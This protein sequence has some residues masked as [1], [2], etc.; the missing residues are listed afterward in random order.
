MRRIGLFAEDFGHEEV[1]KALL[2]ERFGPEYRVD[3]QVK[4]YS[5][6]GGYGAVESEFKRYVHE[7]ESHR[8][9]LPDLIIVATDSNCAGYVERRKRMHGAAGSIQHAV[10]YA[11]PDPHVERWLLLD[12]AAFKKVLGQ[13]CT[14]PDLKCNRDRYKKLLIDA[15]RETGT[16]PLLGG[17][18]HAREIVR[19]MDLD[20]LRKSDKSFGA[21]LEELHA[22]F[23]RWASA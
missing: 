3:V 9:E 13:A 7:L 14:A 15:I 12:S 8:A 4:G 23:R 1:L 10:A 17:M 20:R 21:L 22:R 19:Y 5:V 11:I 2:E 6:R 18:E 16:S